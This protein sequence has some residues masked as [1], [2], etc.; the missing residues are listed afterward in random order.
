MS[1]PAQRR[2]LE[3]LGIERYVLRASADDAAP[4]LAGKRLALACGR[5]AGSALDGRYA[6]LLK[7]LSAA[8]GL[9]ADAVAIVAKPDVALP[10]ICF[11]TEPGER[12]D[13]VLAPPLAALRQ[14][15]AAKRNLWRVLRGLKR[16]VAAH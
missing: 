4:S 1:A 13:N 3:V 14:S 9:P 15:P 5:D 2:L 11:G 12:A 7:H 16:A 10:T 8:L 6:A